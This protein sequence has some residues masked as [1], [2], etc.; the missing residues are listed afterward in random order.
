MTLTVNSDVTWVNGTKL[1]TGRIKA[2]INANQ[3]LLEVAKSIGVETSASDVAKQNRVLIQTDNG[4]YCTVFTSALEKMVEK[5]G[6]YS[7]IQK[8]EKAENKIK[9]IKSELLNALEI[10]KKAEKVVNKDRETLQKSLQAFNSANNVVNDLERRL[11]AV[12]GGNIT[13]NGRVGV[14]TTEFVPAA[15][16]KF[17]RVNLPS[18]IKA[19]IGKEFTVSD[20]RKLVRG[21]IHEASIYATTASYVEKGVLEVT[22]NSKSGRGPGNGRRFKFTSDYLA[23]VSK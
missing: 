14:V 22:N 4:K 9:Q 13:E 16:N 11:N 19:F 6:F 12:I 7:H 2:L 20:V 5:A 17:G 3:S 15:E 23:S 8:F 21:D 10:Q 18:W 1:N